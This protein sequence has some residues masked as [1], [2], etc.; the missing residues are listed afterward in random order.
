MSPNVAAVT[1]QN[2]VGKRATTEMLPNAQRLRLR[3]I[4]AVIKVEVAGIRALVLLLG[5]LGGFLVGCG[6]SLSLATP[7]SSRSSFS[8]T[9]ATGINTRMQSVNVQQ[10]KCLPSSSTDSALKA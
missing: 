6:G 4:P 7:L 3:L 8:F 10:L 1:L 5:D 2:A 9:S